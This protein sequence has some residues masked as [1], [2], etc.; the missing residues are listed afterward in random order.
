M[1]RSPN[2]GSF[3]LRERR[4][5]VRIRNNEMCDIAIS[6]ISEYINKHFP[7]DPDPK[8]LE[9]CFENQ[10]YAKWAAYELIDRLN[11]EAERLPPHITE[12]WREPIPPVDIIAS[13]LDEI[14]CCI[15]EGCNEKLEHILTIAKDV[16]DELI[17]LFL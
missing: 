6:V 8:Y 12:S 14:E 2:K 5:A 9:E 10:S 13:F 15:Y 11:A 7:E 1:E 3:Y 16:G 17:L 4:E